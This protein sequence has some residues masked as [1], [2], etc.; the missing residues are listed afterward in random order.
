MQKS[1]L[2]FPNCS[3]TQKGLLELRV[4]WTRSTSQIARRNRWALLQWRS[5]PK[6]KFRPGSD[7]I[8]SDWRMLRGLPPA[9]WNQ[10]PL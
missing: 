10:I 2:A 8:P 4:G 3:G 5:R 9:L 6:V 7:R 1:L